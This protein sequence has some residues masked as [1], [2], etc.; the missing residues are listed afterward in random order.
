MEIIK[1]LIQQHS[2]IS[3][4]VAIL[5]ILIAGFIL[6]KLKTIAIILI[7]LTSIIFY[8]LMQ[9]GTIDRS[10]I[11]KFKETTKERIMERMK[12]E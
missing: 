10:K 7:L 6:R 4:G 5:F 3:T 12:K 8:V 11:E 1:D 2:Q 9:K